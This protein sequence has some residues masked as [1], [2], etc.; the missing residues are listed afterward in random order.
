MAKNLNLTEAEEKLA[1]LI[2]REAPL[3]SPELV[4][5]AE[6][7][8]DWKK[9]TTYTVLKKLC[10]KGVFKNDSANISVIFTHNELIAQQSRRYIEET[11]GGSLP[12]FITSFMSGKKLTQKQVAELRQL[13]D[14][15]ERG[16]KNG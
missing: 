1:N 6:Q 14:E 10:D 3:T 5:F 16:G 7:E 15:H 9:S 13:I 11:F 4:A 8:M 2:W 12:K